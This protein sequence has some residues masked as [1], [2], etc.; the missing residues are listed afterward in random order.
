MRA[1]P[2]SRRRS[3]PTAGIVPQS[4]KL[5]RI[6]ARP[7][8]DFR[9]LPATRIV[10]MMTLEV[11]SVDQRAYSSGAWE[12]VKSRAGW[13]SCT[14]LAVPC[15]EGRFRCPVTQAAESILPPHKACH[16]GTR[17][18]ESNG[19]DERSELLFR[20]QFPVVRS[21]RGLCTVIRNS[22]YFSVLRR[23]SPCSGNLDDRSR[24]VN[25]GNRR[26]NRRSR[27]STGP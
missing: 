7:S 15:P 26:R 25:A 18:A 9:I 12:R 19:A 6:D 14:A 24:A 1:N 16:D 22:L 13:N 27:C 11:A 5:I 8:G 2:D 10:K 20:R 23:A 3:L 21:T 4:E 17:I